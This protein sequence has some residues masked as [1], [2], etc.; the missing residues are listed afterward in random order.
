M[1][2]TI[3]SGI[4]TQPV[5]VL[6]GAGSSGVALLLWVVAGLIILCIVTGW[7]ELALTI[8]LHYIFRNGNW[9]RISAPR[10]GGDKN[11]LEYIFKRPRYLMKCVFGIAFIIFGNLA[12]NALQF[13]IFMSVA[14]NPMCQEKDGC[15]KQGHVV[16]WGVSVLTFCALINITTRKYAIGLNNFFAVVKV[17][18]VVVLAFMGIIYGST[19]GDT[20]RQ[21]SWQNH[22]DSGK[23]GDIT[24]ALFFA[25][26]PYTGYEQPFYVLA[27]VSQPQRSFAKSTLIAMITALVLFPLV[28]VSY[29]CMT[30]YVGNDALP[31]N[32]VI[33]FFE[34]ISGGTGTESTGSIRGVA[35]LLA[36]FIFGNLMAQT[37]TAARVKQEIA[38]EG[39]LPWSLAFATG[40]DTL[41]S[42]LG[43]W[44]GPAGD[45]LQPQRYQHAVS[46]LDAHR[47]QSPI[48][49]TALHWIFE[50]LL[51]LAVGLSVE[52]SKAYRLLTYLYTFVI[53]GVLGLFTVGGLLYLKIDSIISGRRSRN[54]REKTEWRPWLDPLPAFIAT[55]A[56]AFMLTTAFVPPSDRDQ[57]AVPNWIGP[58]VGWASIGLG[59]LW[60]LGLLFVQWAG[61]WKLETKRLPVV[62]IDEDGQAIQ[63]AELVEHNHI[64]TEGGLR[65]RR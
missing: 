1:N 37:Y 46:N 40:N 18:F 10:S 65:R 49:A 33:S 4:F 38:K 60:Y 61:R 25:M 12:G 17:A 3:A 53:V 34:R 42:R 62:E 29:L 11:Y 64:P 24:M 50:I 56:L 47:E 19:H 13:G 31:E 57:D 51:V 23:L 30:P 26:Y 39:I 63:R 2:R 8:P 54:W 21:I 44:S 22:G 9:M 59:V 35:L 48:A 55:A 27:E 45:K 7:I 20:C 6:R 16:G 28:N 5:N 43:P 41:L 32:I 36:F 52:P 14:I 58:T 15:L